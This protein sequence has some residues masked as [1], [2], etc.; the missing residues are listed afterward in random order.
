VCDITIS[1]SAFITGFAFWLLVTECYNFHFFTVL[2]AC[3][4]RSPNYNQ[5]SLWRNV[6]GEWLCHIMLCICLHEFEHAALLHNFA[7]CPYIYGWDCSTGCGFRLRQSSTQTYYCDPTHRSIPTPQSPALHSAHA[8]ADFSYPLTAL[9]PVTGFSACSA[10][11]HTSLIPA[12]IT[13]FLVL[14]L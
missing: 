8:P 6:N 2:A 10:H 3:S 4:G 11:H 7:Q 1:K 5:G 13:P 9:L 14:L 12:N